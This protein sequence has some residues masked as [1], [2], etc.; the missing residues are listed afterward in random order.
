MVKP[1]LS[2]YTIKIDMKYFFIG[3]DKR[4]IHKVVLSV[5]KV[6]VIAHEINGNGELRYQFFF[7]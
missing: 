3:K 1:L 7:S 4:G 6:V 2:F 5:H